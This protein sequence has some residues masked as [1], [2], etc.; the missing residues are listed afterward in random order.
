MS[1]HF[2]TAVGDNRPTLPSELTEHQIQFARVLGKILARRWRRM[3]VGKDSVKTLGSK[4]RETRGT[5][6]PDPDVVQ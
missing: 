6:H 5:D 1:D 2:K 4:N 3:R